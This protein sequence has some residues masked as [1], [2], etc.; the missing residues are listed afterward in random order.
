M[1][2]EERVGP[3]RVVA[4][5]LAMA[6]VML[7]VAA[8]GEWLLLPS[9]AVHDLDAA[10]LDRAYGSL[11]GRPGLVDAALLWAGLSGPWLV[12][13]VVIVVA[14]TLI[15]VGVARRRALLTAVVGLVGSGLAALCKVL[16]ARP[17]P[18]PDDPITVVAGWS[19]PSGHA[20]NVALG[21]VLLLAL[22]HTAPRRWIR[23]V[24][25]VLVLLG[26]GLTGLDRLVLGVHYLSDVLA[27]YVLG[28]AM[29]VV[30][31]LVLRC[32]PDRLVAVRS[33]GAGPGRSSTPRR[34]R[35]PRPPR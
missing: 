28:T 35:D 19:Y 22:L 25:T 20:T 6:L 24:G 1:T 18:E 8:V 26:T 27:G 30:G 7:L 10:V 33:A 2:E 23:V 13:P 4:A 34:G 5:P 12:H 31:L 29:A 16:V 15:G 32:T 21:A 3:V 9:H 14:S 17:R 11:D